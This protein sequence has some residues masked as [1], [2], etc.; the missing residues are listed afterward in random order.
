[1]F[2]RMT[3]VRT[4]VSEEYIASITKVRRIS[5]QGKKLVAN[6]SLLITA[7]VPS[8]LS[9]LTLM[10]ETIL[11]S[12]TSVLKRATRRHVSKDGFFFQV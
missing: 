11:F 5:S 6:Y 4:G 1:M 10:M 9:I 8:S 3:L 12:E 7:N 2:Y